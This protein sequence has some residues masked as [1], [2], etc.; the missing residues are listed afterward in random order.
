[1]CRCRDAAMPDE[2][3]NSSDGP[4]SANSST[5]RPT[6][7]CSLSLRASNQPAN[8][9]VPSTSQATSDHAIDSI[10]RP[11]LYSVPSAPQEIREMSSKPD[12]LEAVRSLADTLQPFPTMTESGSFVGR[13]KNSGWSP[14][15]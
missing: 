1:M 11:E 9:S 14:G 13:E 7:I 3:G 10:M 15:L 5:T 12:D 8:S 2:F 4:C 6:L